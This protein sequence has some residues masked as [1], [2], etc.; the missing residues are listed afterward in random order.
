MTE[1]AQANEYIFRWD[2]AADP[3]AVAALRAAL[4]AT[5]IDTSQG[6]GFELWR[7]EATLDD[8]T[9]AALTCD[10]V[11]GDITVQLDYAQANASITGADWAAAPDAGFSEDPKT[12]K[13]WGLDN[14]GQT[15]GKID[16]DID[17][18]EAW[19]QSRGSGVVVAVLDTGVDYTHA[20]LAANMWVNPGEI[21]GNG[22]DD[23]GNGYVDDVHGYD[24]AYNDADPMDRNG[25]GTHVAG[26]IAA[27]ADNGTGVAG[28]APEAQ[29]M[30][31]KFLDDNGNGSLFDAIQALDY[32]VMMGAQVSNN[33]WGSGSYSSALA[34]AITLAGA[35][36][37]TVVAAA[38][39]DST[40]T[41]LS[42]HYPA[43]YDAANLIAVAATDDADRLAY[44]SNYGI[45][46]VD[47]AAPGQ[48]IYSTLPGDS[49]GTNSGTSMATPHVTGIVALLLAQNPT[50]SPEAIRDL[51]IDTSDPMAALASRSV[52]GGRVN[53]A[54]ALDAAQTVDIAGRV[55][56]DTGRGL[57]GWQVFLDL[58]GDGHAGA[59]E[60]VVLTDADGAYRFSD[61]DSASYRVVA[62]IAP[63]YAPY[64][65][66]SAG[67]NAVAASGGA[68]PYRSTAAADA[69]TDTVTT[70][71]VLCTD[72][73]GPMSVALPF[74]FPFFD[75][76]YDRVTVTP[77]GLLC[78]GAS[79]QTIAAPGLS[80]APAAS[81]AAFWSDLT[82]VF[83]GAIRGRSDTAAGTY[84]IHFDELRG[85]DGAGLFSFQI[86]LHSDGDISVRYIDMSAPPADAGIGLIGPD[87]TRH[88]LEVADTLA[89][90]GVRFTTKPQTAAVADIAASGTT[91]APDFVVQA[92]DTTD[93]GAITGRV[94][95]DTDGDGLRDWGEA[96][97]A[98]RVVWLDANDNAILDAGEVLT[99]TDAA[100]AYAF[101]GLAPGRHRV[102]QV[103]PT[104]WTATATG[105]AEYRL[106]GEDAGGLSV[107][108]FQW[109]S[110]PGQVTELTGLGDDQSLHVDL[111]FLFPFFGAGYGA[112]TISAN[113]YLTFGGDG[114]VHQNQPLT[115]A[116]LPGPMIAAFWDD[117]SAEAARVIYWYDPTADQVVVSFTGMTRYDSDD[118]LSFQVVLGSAGDIEMHYLAVGDTV[119]SATVGIADGGGAAVEILHTAADTGL[120]DE[121]AFRFTPIAAADTGQDVI[122]GTSGTVTGVDLGSRPGSG[123]VPLPDMV[124]PFES[125]VLASLI[126]A[127]TLL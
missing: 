47:V 39:N 8:A 87:G 10:G 111:P 56:E 27:V 108:D 70:G 31:L 42:G 14:T 107:A 15:G 24:F 54:A 80:N 37:H 79:S 123:F 75:V 73:W 95:L 50:L 5:V 40:N 30:A 120:H 17:A 19:A 91:T 45:T 94:W 13:L 110:A 57:V 90:G 124:T 103:D 74:A 65:P 62:Q 53:A 59:G 96:G 61:L 116:A 89:N 35:A 81:I 51:L 64:D 82:T 122:V 12:D 21:A 26:T 92:L 117:L 4:G 60:P 97:L 18:P 44:F 34:G 125:A 2:T 9:L 102:A 126:D 32:A 118:P 43:S 6:W 11:Y 115:G 67:T 66:T 33:S 49:Y 25:H 100:G 28:V 78:F 46:T 38:G 3:T 36:G 77:D 83:G 119:D 7:T 112:V 29:I 22:I 71:N 109:H 104:G 85:A 52:S 72:N 16:A 1:T 41:D 114:S 23:D 84:T 88:I 20:D 99:V 113:G 76:S 86:V 55:I 101:D 48:S 127:A 106:A 105:T 98:G 68:S 93:H 63:G 121:I 69:W 58:D